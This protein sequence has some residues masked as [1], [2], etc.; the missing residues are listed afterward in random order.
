MKRIFK[1]FAAVFFTAILVV[2]CTTE[3]TREEKVSA[4]INEVG[5]PFFVVNTVPGDL[6][7][8]SGALDG[9]LPFTYEMLFTFFIDEEATGV[10]Y[11]TDVQIIVSKGESFTPDFFGVFKIKNQDVF[12]ELLE[13]EANADILEKDGFKYAIKESDQYVIVWNE[14]FAMAS[15]IPIN[16]MDLFSGGGSNQGMKAVDRCI[17]LIGAANEGEIDTEYA[18]FLK[19]ESDIAMRFSGKGFFSYITEMAMGE[20]EELEKNKDLIEGINADMF[21]NFN[22]GSIDFQS[23]SDL[24]DKVKEEIAFLKDDAIGS[25]LMGYGNS[26]NPALT[27]SYNADVTEMLDYM[28][29]TMSA[30]DYENF[31]SEL[32]GIGLTVDQAKSA[33]SGELLVL[34]D[35]VEIIEQE[36][37]WGYGDPYVSKEP[38][39][40]FAIVVGVS[41]A[42]V[43]SGM[44]EESP[45]IADGVIKNGDAF[46]VLKE[47]V[48]LATNDSLWA[49]KAA[50]GQTVKVKD[51]SG[52]ISANPLGFF[53]DF[54]FLAGMG[55][56]DDVE[57]VGELIE[58][59]QGG[60][61]MDEMVLSII[62]KDKTQ[63][64]LRVL[65]EAIS[66]SLEDHEGQEDL[67]AELEAAAALEALES[68]I[69]NLDELE[70]ELDNALDALED[71]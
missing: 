29:E 40:V 57:I 56:L 5:S 25:K 33:L 21:I 36:Y 3:R 53:A 35:R 23:V 22:D 28:E 11:D 47:D 17:R 38:Y 12:A 64:S 54:T 2:G 60:G 26:E 48:L 49:M 6:I 14:E 61:N 4:I 18:E 34:V 45:A 13:T 7:E 63:N 70:E 37:D 30:Y 44:A 58:S 69:E 10:D 9:A 16:L 1:Q 67:E 27:F 31:E 71:L 62:L 65:T 51:Q 15:N 42:S 55:D 41:D 59:V 43:F 68:E 50:S 24:S 20:S 8:K 39:P 46:I 19:D 66:S 32:G 52:M